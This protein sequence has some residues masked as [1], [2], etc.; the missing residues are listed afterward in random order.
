M[1]TTFDDFLLE[2]KLR[3]NITIKVNKESENSFI[4]KRFLENNKKENTNFIINTRLISSIKL[5]NDKYINILWCHD[6][7][8]HN[9]YERIKKRTTFNDVYEFNDTIIK[10][11][12]ILFSNK[13]ESFT[14]KGKYD[15]FLLENKI[16]LLL[17]VD[18]KFFDK[19][20]INV[21]IITISTSSFNK[22]VKMI[23]VDE[24]DF[25]N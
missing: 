12:K 5:L 24:D 10:T 6:D 15:I 7:K 16:H 23:N 21:T 13:K 25:L 4:A 2:A 1:I 18:P 3:D 8:K 20:Y 22:V 14:E 11:L 17:K 9:L 19:Q